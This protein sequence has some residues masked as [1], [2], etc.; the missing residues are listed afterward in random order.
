MPAYNR[1]D[2]ICEAID[3]ILAQTTGRF[4][5]IVIDDGS[6]DDT[7]TIARS[8]GPPVI[9]HSQS[10]Q[11]IGG[12]L[13]HGLRLGTGEW[14]AFLDSDD[15]WTPEKTALQ[16]AHLE[17]HP[18]TDLVFGHGD[19]FIS[20]E[21]PKGKITLG[22]RQTGPRPVP[23]Y[24]TLLSRRDTFMRV[25]FFDDKIKLGQFIDWLARARTSGLVEGTVNDCVLR[26]RIHGENTT[27]KQR[28]NYRDYLKVLKGNIDRIRSAAASDRQA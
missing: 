28:A 19:E 12:A 8:Y 3:S 17:K 27:M 23:S 21:I 18:A 26:R 16:F 20:P 5:I 4:E 25:G 11:G 1:K 10:N 22:T 15:L 2:Y 9:C 14:L 6:T 7:A 13:N 24:G